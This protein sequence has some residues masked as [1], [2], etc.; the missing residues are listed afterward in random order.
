MGNLEMVSSHS[1]SSRT[2][3]DS[4]V[5]HTPSTVS[6]KCNRVCIIYIQYIYKEYCQYIDISEF[7]LLPELGIGI[8]PKIQFRSGS[9]AN[10]SGMYATHTH[11]IAYAQRHIP[12]FS[13]FWLDL[14]LSVEVQSNYQLCYSFRIA[15]LP[16]GFFY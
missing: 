5:Y 10:I 1:L 13:L 8:A 7:F 12:Q 2:R 3:F 16:N 11:L 6:S 15:F 4:I 9:N 14:F